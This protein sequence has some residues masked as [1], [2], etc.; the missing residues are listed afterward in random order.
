MLCL[1][2]LKRIVFLFIAILI[3]LIPVF[4]SC[5]LIV[6]IIAVPLSFKIISFF[7][8]IIPMVSLFAIPLATCLAVQIPMGNLFI[9]DEV[10]NF[11]FWRRARKALV[12]AVSLFSLLVSIFF[13]P[14]IFQWAP[15][16]YWQ[17]KKL[18][19]K[20]AQQ[21]I[22]NLEPNQFHTINDRAMLFFKQKN[23][24]QNIIT[25]QKVL[26]MFKE[27]DG[28]RYVM[29]AESGEYAQDAFYLYK[30][31]IYNT[32]EGQHYITSFKKLQVT[33]DKLFG[34]TK[35]TFSKQP[36]FMTWYDLVNN[37]DSNDVAWKEFHKRIIQIIW[38]LLFPFLALWSILLLARKKSNLLMSV[39]LS[40]S[41]FLFSYITVN[42]GALL[43][44]KSLFP[45]ISFYSI[46]LVCAISLY[47][48]YRKKW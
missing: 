10:L 18:I 44:H 41:I 45:L 21:H 24:Q 12:V 2:Y 5:D 27:K 28:K 40:G 46:P 13:V 25:F 36:K 37:K 47:M 42:V 48:R 19:V 32:N 34:K 20:L 4:A 23:T 38:Q 30:G 15:E 31:S 43:L 3:G 11:Y 29:T 7:L 16:S 22:E 17:G 33:M 35:S 6:R 8:L 9:E 1:H 26:F 14:L 39:I